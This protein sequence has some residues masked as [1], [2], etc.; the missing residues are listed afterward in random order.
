[1]MKRN[2]ASILPTLGDIFDLDIRVEWVVDKLI[3][4]DSITV[5][6]G[7]GGSGKTWIMIQISSCVSDEK[8]FAGLPTLKMPCYYVDFENSLATLH[9]R[10]TVLG[11]SSLKVWH[12]SNPKPPPRL[13]SK[14]WGQYK[15][16]E[17]GLLI[18]DTL[19][20]S[21]LQDENSSRAMAFIMARLKELRDMGFTIILI[22]HSP[23][24]NDQTYKGSTAIVDQCDHVLSLDRVNGGGQEI[25]GED[26]KLPLRL[27]VRGKTR[28]EPFS[29]YLRFDPSKGFEK[30]EDPPDPDEE[31]LKIIFDLIVK[32]K[33]GKKIA[34][35][36]S[37]IAE[38]VKDHGINKKRLLRLLKKGEG[39]FWNLI[40]DPHSKAKI[41]DPII[42]KTVD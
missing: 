16:L 13:D 4:K 21:Q 34:P 32:F 35:N 19:R 15:K 30:A 11:R 10:A 1:M 20:S 41:Y 33:K 28:Y 7:K 37:H 38:M 9:Y 8:P 25:D 5:L 36:Q 23:K 29:I 17:P 14:E 26:W 6:H 40:P 31:S 24:G 12:V 2:L 18:F 3:P 22:H 27:G 42:P 39:E